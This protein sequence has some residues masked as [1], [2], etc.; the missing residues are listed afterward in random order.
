MFTAVYCFLC[1]AGFVHKKRTLMKNLFCRQCILYWF[2]IFHLLFK[3]S[4]H[5]GLEATTPRSRFT[6]L[7]NC[8]SQAPQFLIIHIMPSTWKTASFL[9]AR[10]NICHVDF[11]HHRGDSSDLNLKS[12]MRKHNSD[13]DLNEQDKMST[14]IWCL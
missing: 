13:T 1:I 8:A 4:L 3:L 11:S 14:N 5:L 2:L 12:K 9:C 7:T 6:R 10:H